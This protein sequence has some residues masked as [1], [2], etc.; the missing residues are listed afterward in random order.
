MRLMSAAIVGCERRVTG[1][2][3][4]R[5][6]EQYLAGASDVQCGRIDQ[7]DFKDSALGYVRK[8]R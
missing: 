5:R 4:L 2:I 7:I 6:L 1:T 8:Y 3:A